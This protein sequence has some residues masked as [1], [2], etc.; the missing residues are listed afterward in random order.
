MPVP[1]A[2]TEETAGA[3]VSRVKVR[4]VAGPVLPAASVADT[5]TVLAPWARPDVGVMVKTPEPFAVPVPTVAP[6]IVSVTV[7]PASAVPGMAGVWGALS[8]PAATGLRGR[9]AKG[10]GDR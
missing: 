2:V 10:G 5:D 4:L 7:E 8:G 3:P 9:G 1:E 6:P